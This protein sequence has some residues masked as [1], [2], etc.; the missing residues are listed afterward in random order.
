MQKAP[1]QPY[2]M[3]I[4]EFPTGEVQIRTYSKTFGEHK[5]EKKPSRKQPKK[6]P[7]AYLEGFGECTVYTQ[8]EWAAYEKKRALN[9][10][11]SMQNTKKA[12]YRIA[13][14]IKWEYMLTITFDQSKIPYERTDYKKCARLGC[15][16]LRNQR[17]TSPDIK[18]L[19]IG[20]PHKRLEDNGLPAWHFHCLVADVP[21]MIFTDS[22]RVAVGKKS[23][24]KKRGIKGRPILNVGGWKYGWSTATR[25]EGDD[26]VKVSKYVL[27]YITKT[28]V[29]NIRGKGVHR[30]YVSKNIPKP[31][32]TR[33]NIKQSRMDEYINE[34][35]ENRDKEIASTH[36]SSR[37]IDTTFYELKD[38]EGDK[39]YDNPTAE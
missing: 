18:F 29:T 8:E 25:I 14:S 34:I 2:N 33:K 37:Y 20:E 16:F 28:F 1:I 6:Q 11:N 23:Y 19:V 7:T 12:V 24:S 3:Q 22:G 21:G 17:R 9:L 35:L 26:Y 5:P 39:D 10:Y 13:R 4:I 36:T 31:Q 15:Q 32:I 30:Y 27:K 38:K